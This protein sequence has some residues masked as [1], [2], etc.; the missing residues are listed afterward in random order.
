MSKS[1]DEI[2]QKVTNLLNEN[3]IGFHVLGVN[4]A[5][6]GF[7]YMK[8]FP[9][10]VYFTFKGKTETFDF[11]MGK[12]HVTKLGVPKKPSS[13]DVLYCLLLDASAYDINFYHWCAAYGYDRNHISA[14][15]CYRECLDNIE[16]LHNVFTTA[17]L[18]KL[19]ELLQ[20]Y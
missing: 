18:A 11:S 13:A 15:N 3:Q 5:H 12:A 16:K 1:N 19:N 17:Q 7:R 9:W 20:D 2:V 4:P 6:E 8:A 10:K 14:F